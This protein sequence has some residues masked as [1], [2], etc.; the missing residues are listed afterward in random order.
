MNVGTI[1]DI[2]IFFPSFVIYFDALEDIYENDWNF[3]HRYMQHLFYNEQ[4]PDLESE[5]AKYLLAS[6]TVISPQYHEEDQ[7]DEILQTC[8]TFDRWEITDRDICLIQIGKPNC[9]IP[10]TVCIRD[11]S[12]R[13]LKPLFTSLFISESW[14][15]S[16][17][18]I[19]FLQELW[20]ELMNGVFDLD[21]MLKEA[22][23]VCYPSEGKTPEPEPE[24]YRR[25]I[26]QVLQTFHE[27]ESGIA[28]RA[29]DAW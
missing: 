16:R 8:Y 20:K 24:V 29:M 3:I 13:G 9:N 26:T 28:N 22:T 25:T 5:R 6:S 21:Q 27:R 17:S 12:K 14:G 11:F 4:C 2:G 1:K 15:V 7:D 23:E 10:Y 19:T 18:D